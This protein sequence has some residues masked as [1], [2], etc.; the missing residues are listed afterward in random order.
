MIDN[1]NSIEWFTGADN[2]TVY[3]T[4]RRH[5]N[6]VRRLA[7]QFP[8]EVQVTDVNQDGSIVAHVPLRYIHITRPAQRQMSEEQRKASAE[9]LKAYRESF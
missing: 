2:V 4:Q 7:Q 6:K 8:D 5:I 1:E 3:L 9:R